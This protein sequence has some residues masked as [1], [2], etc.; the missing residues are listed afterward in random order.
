MF[1]GLEI[2]CTHGYVRSDDLF[3]TAGFWVDFFNSVNS[4]QTVEGVY[5]SME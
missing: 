4:K 5:F 2:V 1:T 3:L